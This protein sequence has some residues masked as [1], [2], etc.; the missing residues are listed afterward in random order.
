VKTTRHLINNLFIEWLA[1]ALTLILALLLRQHRVHAIDPYTGQEVVIR[2]S[3]SLF[4]IPVIAWPVI[5]F[6]LGIVVYFN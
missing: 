5:F 4:F 3:H 1:A 6:V 2:P